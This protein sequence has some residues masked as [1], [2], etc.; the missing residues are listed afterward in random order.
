MPNTTGN[1]TTTL[2][3]QDV[4]VSNDADSP[5]PH[6]QVAALTVEFDDVDGC[7]ALTQ[8]ETTI[9]MTANQALQLAAAI[10]NTDDVAKDAA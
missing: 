10:A 9:V 4:I 1:A 7:V 2:I 8:H 5:I 3:A 6:L